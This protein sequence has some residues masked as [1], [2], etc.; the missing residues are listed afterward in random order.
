MTRLVFAVVLALIT[1]CQTNKPANKGAGSAVTPTPTPSA[2]ADAPAVVA[3]AADMGSG[4]GSS[5]GSGAG[6][7]MGSGTGSSAAMGSGAGSAAGGTEF[8]KL[9]HEEK[10]KF[11]K[12][13]VMPVMKPVFQKLAP[14]DSAPFG[15]KTCH[16]KDPQGTKYKMPNPEL[17]PLDFEQ[18]KA[19]KEDPKMV[20]FMSK[21]VKPTMAKILAMPEMSQTEPEGMARIFA[22]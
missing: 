5:M 16:G 4:A 22:I 13:K 21:Q 11:M 2:V 9:T 14:R 20:E 1:A 19:G 10:I 8:D 12:T 3:D 7:S 17:K 15:C 18:I 6:S